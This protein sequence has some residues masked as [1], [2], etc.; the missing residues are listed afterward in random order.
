MKMPGSY[1]TKFLVLIFLM[2]LVGCA[3]DYKLDSNAKLAKEY[4]LQK[5]YSVKSYEGN[6]VYTFQ[7]KDLVEMPHKM[8][9]SLQSVKPDDYIGKEIIQER[10]IVKNHPVGKIYKSKTAVNVFL[11]EGKVIGGTSYPAVDGMSGWG[12]SLDGKTAEELVGKNIQEW[13]VEWE[14]TYGE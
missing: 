9:W 7:R 8:I 2:L 11:F 3:A 6:Y 12:Y 1:G 10:F 13:L 14:K 4:L 5:G